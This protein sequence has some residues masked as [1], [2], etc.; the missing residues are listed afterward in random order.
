[1][2][3]TTSNRPF[4]ATS[5]TTIPSQAMPQQNSNLDTVKEILNDIKMW[6]MIIT[7]IILKIVII[8]AIRLCRK[9]YKIHNQ[10]IIQR[11]SRTSPQI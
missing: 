3:L 7:I 11:H 2:N 9:G 4:L 1:M 5:S 10:N 6:I 8:K